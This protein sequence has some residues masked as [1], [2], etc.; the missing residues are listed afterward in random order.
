[1]TLLLFKIFL[2]VFS[3]PYSQ[4]SVILKGN[5]LFEEIEGQQLNQ[6]F[7]TFSRKVDTSELEHFAITLLSSA[8]LYENFCENIQT[9]D[10]AAKASE[11]KFE[12]NFKVGGNGPYSNAL[13]TCKAKGARLPEVRT[14]QDKRELEDLMKQHNITQVRAGLRYDKISNQYQYSSDNSNARK[15]TI[16][17]HVYYGG[18]YKNQNY[19]AYWTD[20]KFLRGYAERYP[21][22]YVTTTYGMKLRMMDEGTLDQSSLIICEKRHTVPQDTVESNVLIQVAA[23]ACRRDLQSIKDTTTNAVDEI[24][25]IVNLD[26]N[27]TSTPTAMDHFLPTIVR[28]KRDLATLGALGAFGTI[29]GG[30]SYVLKSILDS[31]FGSTRYAKQSDLMKIAHKVDDLKI[32]QD[33]LVIVTTKIKEAIARLEQEIS[34][35]YTGIATLNMESE[36][37]QLNR[38]LQTVLTTTLLKYSQALMAAKDRR[39]HP[40]A[41]SQMELKELSLKSFSA[42][43]VHLDTN[44]NNV[45]TGVV[46]DKNTIVFIFDIPIIQQDKLFN[47]YTIIP[48]P[49]FQNNDTFY[50][51]IDA[52]NIA[53]SKHGDKYTTLSDKEMQKCT[54]DPPVCLSH[55]PITPMTMQKLCVVSTYTSNKLTCPLKQSTQKLKPFLYFQDA[56]LF[57]SV[58]HNTSLYIKCHKTTQFAEYYEQTVT[59]SGIGEAVYRPSCTVNLP[60]GTSYNTPSDTVVHVLQDW[61]IFNIRQALPHEDIVQITIPTITSDLAFKVETQNEPTSI[62]EVFG[63]YDMLDFALFLV[64]TLGPIILMILLAVCFYPRFKR[65]TLARMQP[66]IELHKPA[67]K[68]APQKHFWYD[69]ETGRPIPPMTP[70]LKTTSL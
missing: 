1:M 65:W 58:P 45:Q 11:T 29:I 17:P 52:S 33:E 60:D 35:M 32:N 18:E 38:Y 10:T 30:T 21:L 2:V 62:G 19:E 54:N 67:P 41:L 15:E 43:K 23:H 44:I 61:P 14:V 3:F 46:I 6:E 5:L 36:V 8:K 9:L 28:S 56:K 24:R 25:T 40:Y 16:F 69:L 20:D 42:Y 55:I 34:T 49:T 53:I 68:E 51:D 64:S 27:F 22:A 31:V 39:T 66:N 7:M 47:F 48:V 12:P 13:A 57:Y 4:T 50:P 70:I 59:I 37:K 63:K 26:F